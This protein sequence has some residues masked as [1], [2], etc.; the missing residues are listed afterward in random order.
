MK[1]LMTYFTQIR[2]QIVRLRGPR[3]GT[4]NNDISNASAVGQITLTALETE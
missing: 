3:F 4:P 2:G 1:L